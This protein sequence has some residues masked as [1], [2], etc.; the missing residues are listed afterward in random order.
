[1]KVRNLS[2]IVGLVLLSAILLAVPAQAG[3]TRTPFVFRGVDG[4]R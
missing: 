1:M 4:T 3:R 2:M